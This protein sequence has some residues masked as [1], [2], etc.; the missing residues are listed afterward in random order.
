MDVSLAELPANPGADEA[1]TAAMAG[2][3]GVADLAD[4]RTAA[5]VGLGGGGPWVRLC[6]GVGRQRGRP[7]GTD[8]A[9]GRTGAA[10]LAGLAVAVKDLVAVAGL[11]VGAGS[12]ARSAAPVEPRDA[13][14]VARLR[15]AGA[16]IAG[17][18]AL[19]ELAF[20]VTGINDRVGFPTHP[21]DAG[22]IPG[23]SS[24]GS[25]VAVA[26]GSCDLAIGTDTGGSVRIPAALC[27]VVGFKPN[28]GRYPLDG[29]LALSP[30]L[31]HVGFLARTTAPITMAHEALTGE[32]VGAHRPERLG[33]DSAALDAADD[34]VTAAV[35]R[36]L[37]AIRAMSCTIVD[38]AWPDVAEVVDVSSTVM[39]AEAAAVHRVLLARHGDQVGPDVAARLAAGARISDADYRQARSAARE[40]EA[41]VRATLAGV[42]AV[43]GP[44]TSLAAPTIAAA[45]T[46]ENL[47]RGLVRTTRLANLTGVPA[48]SIPVHTDGLPVGLQ[49]VAAT[50]AL[51]LGL[52]TTLHPVVAA[53]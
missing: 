19:H 15:Q 37:D 27:G 42:D 7:A 32:A 45:R 28:R 23:G 3:G 41:S 24:S 51:A 36:A 5:R 1:L 39:F 30:S 26:D 31:D 25:A 13:A 49:L 2:A 48:V 14:V 12:R 9:P 53:H 40:I 4:Q 33:L 22:R 44:T 46:D 50:D 11:P 52:A 47:P 21:H 17:T 38:V 18:V 16:A 43:V 10:G 8:G 20:G 29:V 6:D 35:D 34:E